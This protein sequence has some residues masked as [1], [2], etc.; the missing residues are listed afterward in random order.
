M[1]MLKNLLQLGMKSLMKE[2]IDEAPK[3][4]PAEQIPAYLKGKGVTEDELKFSEVEFPKT[5]VVTREQLQEAEKARADKFQVKSIGEPENPNHLSARTETGYNSVNLL[6]HKSLAE[7]YSY[8][9]DIYTFSGGRQSAIPARSHWSPIDGSDDPVRDYIAHARRQDA[10]IKGKNAR[11]VLEVQS[12]TAS[13][14]I[15]DKKKITREEAAIAHPLVLTKPEYTSTLA[16]LMD[17]DYSTPEG[18]AWVDQVQYYMKKDLESGPGGVAAAKRRL[19][20]VLNGTVDQPWVK[21]YKR[22]VLEAQLEQALAD[23]K[24]LFVV[25][26]DGPAVSGLA[27]GGNQEWYSK[28][29]PG[30]LQRI[31]KRRGLEYSEILPESKKLSGQSE[32]FMEKLG[33][34]EFGQRLTD[35][36][37]RR[38]TFYEGLDLNELEDTRMLHFDELTSTIEAHY[39]IKMGLD[40]MPD[41][42]AD[43]FDKIYYNIDMQLPVRK[44]VEDLNAYL[45]DE[46]PTDLAIIIDMYNVTEFYNNI[47]KL[48]SERWL[49]NLQAGAIDP[50]SP[51]AAKGAVSN[52]IDDVLDVAGVNGND[53]AFATWREETETLG[54]ALQESYDKEDW[55]KVRSIA[56]QIRDKTLEV[57]RIKAKASLDK[58]V[59]T[60]YAAID[61]SKKPTSGTY[62]YASPVVAAYAAHS[63]F[64]AGVK[65]EQ[66]KQRMQEAGADDDEVFNAIR[67]AKFIEEAKRK[68]VSD[69][70]IKLF[71]E[72]KE[73]K[74]KVQRT[75]NP[76]RSKQ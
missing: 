31:A 71:I 57:T 25:P 24:E 50:I 30:E 72:K 61:L 32:Q 35:H 36:I 10:K 17:A 13:R 15:R 45:K 59:G 27:R 3:K 1:A 19:Q 38:K 18:R 29:L 62:L 8:R 48:P 67:D 46:L 9:E 28:V 53:G 33:K 64:M 7:P 56:R 75:V 14:L 43:K 76:S 23:G 63:A 6:D 49:I 51:G 58:P 66:I 26:I 52:H 22:K 74:I 60:R 70:T 20:E 65:E 40:E 21:N 34:T 68:G 4:L 54:T 73:P 16:K 41:Q 37:A 5:G 12:D 2:A 42:L 69:D 55:A 39:G 47:Y 44:A 11:M